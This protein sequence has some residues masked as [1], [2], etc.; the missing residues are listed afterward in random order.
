[1]LIEDKYQ[2]SDWVKKNTIMYERTVESEF[3]NKLRENLLAGEEDFTL[4]YVGDIN[5]SDFTEA[6]ID[7][8]YEIEDLSTAS[9]F[10][11]LRYNIRSIR[12]NVSGFANNLTIHYQIV[13][14][15]SKEQTIALEEEID[16]LLKKWRI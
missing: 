4:T 10:D 5:L 8:V 12:T 3:V 6:M 9:D 15:E 13:Y 1:Y 14:N 2:F 11:Y 7:K 16:G